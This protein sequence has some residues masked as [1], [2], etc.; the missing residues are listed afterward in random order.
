MIKRKIQIQISLLLLGTLVYALPPERT[1]Y[2]E[3]RFLIYLNQDVSLDKSNMKLGKPVTGMP[4]FDQLLDH[5]DILKMEK[6]L[7]SATSDDFSDGIDLSK[8]Y[9]LR[10]EAGSQSVDQLIDEFNKDPNVLYSEYEGI[11][12][13][14]YTPNDARYP[15][16]WF[17]DKI[18]APETWDLWDIA[19]GDFPGNT[20]IVLASVDSGVEYTHPDLWE[21]AWVNQAEVPESIFNAVDTD[22]SGTVT[23]TE[24][25]AYLTDLNAD[26]SINLQD[27]LAPGS[28]FMDGIDGDDWDETPSSYVDDLFGWDISGTTSGSDADND[29][30]AALGGIADLSPLQHGTHVA[31]L[32]CATTDNG[33]GIASTIYNGSFMSVKCLY[34]EDPNGYISGGYAGM[35]YAAKAGADIINVSWGSSSWSETNQAIINNIFY[36]YGALIVGSA[37]NGDDLGLPN[38]D[39]RY[40]SGYDNVISVTAVSP[41]DI[42][43]WANY[44]SGEGD[45][46]FFGVDLSAPGEGIY[47]TIFPAWGSYAAWDGTSMASPIVASA[48]GLLKSAHPAES[49]EWLIESI[50]G[51]TDPIDQLNPTY[52]D[53]LG[54]GRLNIYN[55]LAQYIYPRIS[56][57]SYSLEILNDDGNGQ[58][59]AGE[60]AYMRIN[61]FNSQGWVAAS[62]VDA[63]LRTTSPNIDIIDSTGHYT[64]INDGSLAVN[65]LDRFKISVPSDVPSGIIDMS[66]EVTANQSSDHPY[67][68]ILDFQIE[69]S[70]WQEN[71][72]VLSE[73]IKSGT[74]VVDL[75]GD[76]HNEIVYAA[77]DSLL[78]AIG[79]DGIE[80]S[81][82]PVYLNSVLDASP[83]VGD[84][85]NDGDLEV[86]IGSRDYNL[87]VVQHDGSYE[88]IYTALG[89][90]WATSTLYDLDKDGDLEIITMTYTGDLE[91]L[92]HDGTAFNTYFPQNFGSST[93]VSVA[94]G[95]VNSDGSPNIVLAGSDKNLHV[96]NLDGTEV[97]GFPVTLSDRVKSSVVLTNLDDS[98]DGSLEILFGGNDNYLHVYNSSGSELWNYSSGGQDVQTDPAVSDID[99]D[100]DLEII[101]VGVTRDIYA[102]DHTGTLLAGWP[103][104]T[105]GS[106]YSTPAIADVDGDGIAEIFFGSTDYNLYGLHL[107]GSN[108]IGFPA[109]LSG[110]VHGSVSLADFD[111]DGDV[112]IIAGTTKDLAVLDLPGVGE[113]TRYWPTHRGNLHRTGAFYYTP[114]GIAQGKTL[115]TAYKLS[116]NYPNPFNPSTKIDFEIP[117]AAYVK[118]EIMDIRG[119]VV[120]TLV[121]EYL[122]ASDYTV[123]WTGNI[124]GKA[125]SAGLYLYRLST[126]AGNMIRKMILLK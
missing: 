1:K 112:E 89:Y 10:I 69:V 57:D 53:Q 30:M 117:E 96:M 118:L 60:E 9:R 111:G 11:D 108:I 116:D 73:M 77:Y 21:R 74:A 102:L 33:T 75:D 41:Y 71:F 107:D 76:G 95:D 93:T 15:N 39:P 61:L 123:T 18:Q 83:A 42:F 19:S 23:P 12:Y 25:V 80:L 92:H 115:P 38:G 48:F 4:S 84:I 43:S 63:I 62:D 106:I 110:K 97:S 99:N 20:N 68:I 114:V 24:I 52:A 124:N 27:A 55:A 8:V 91:L 44:G 120:E 45:P 6:Y 70:M 49:N 50:L 65:I 32:L 100:G 121:S 34:D 119:R 28:P 47:S 46:K 14:D 7:P 98:A 51:S 58:L 81:G 90:I 104:S 94:V 2:F 22:A 82:F 35:L 31:G 109:R 59:S 3:D 101:F 16:Q 37:G 113:I 72:P 40:P 126:P 17:L 105:G 85:D 64:S 67:S 79:P 5:H 125:A 66:L 54:T 122:N 56:Y 36:N 13:L 103:I 29:P 87:Y 78:H 88:S 86:V 26:G